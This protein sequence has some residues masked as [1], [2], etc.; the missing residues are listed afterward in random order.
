MNLG[1]KQDHQ[2]KDP[3]TCGARD[4]LKVHGGVQVEEEEQRQA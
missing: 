2:E 1:W 3:R 4:A